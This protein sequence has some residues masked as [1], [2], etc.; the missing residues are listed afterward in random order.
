MVKN[1]NTIALNKKVLHDYFIEQT[2]E[3]GISLLG[4][5][6]KSLRNK[7]IQLKESYINTSSKELFLIGAHISPLITASNHIDTNPVRSRKLLL[8]AIEIKKIKDKI[9]QK[10]LTALALSLYWVRGKI[11]LKVVIAKGKKNYDKRQV[12]KE[13]DWQRSKQIL[14]KMKNR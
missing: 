5:E 3:A 12:L 9:G 8:H 4:W 10:G 2:F 11:K 13:K 1:N 7:K 14:L 6:V